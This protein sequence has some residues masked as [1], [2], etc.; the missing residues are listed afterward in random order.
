MKT[1]SLITAALLLGT[2][3]DLFAAV[4]KTDRFVQKWNAPSNT[5]VIENPIGNIEVHATDEPMVTATVTKTVSGVDARALEEGR[6]LTAVGAAGDDNIRVLRTVLPPI[7]STRWTSSVSWVVR[8]P[9]TVHVR[10]ASNSSERIRVSGIRANVIIKNFS[11]TVL[12]DN[13]GAAVVES[14][15]GSIVYDA[16]KP[17]ANAKLSSINGDIHVI[18]APDANF[19]WVADTI[20][21]DYRTTMPVRGTL[22]GTVLRASVNAP[23]GPIIETLAM[24]GR[25]YLL[26]K[27]TTAAQA[28]SVRTMRD[29]ISQV[30][31]ASLAEATRQQVVQGRFAYQTSLG[32]VAVNEVRGE[33][34][35]H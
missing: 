27:N 8:V 17:F 16:G 7:R 6:H 19:R 34:I 30:Q 24:M 35:V 14:V 3:G 13:V 9:R 22:I 12:I 11:G 20:K 18:V 10:I 32:N 5:V 21:G 31:A 23:G 29:S 25:I 15:N 4:S 28:Q 33:A 26:R 2:A 1:V